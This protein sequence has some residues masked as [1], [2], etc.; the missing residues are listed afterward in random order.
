[1]KTI[2]LPPADKELEDAV[3]YYNDQLHGLGNQFYDAVITAIEFIRK[4]P[5]G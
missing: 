3:I 4:F 2:F 1:M 5:Q